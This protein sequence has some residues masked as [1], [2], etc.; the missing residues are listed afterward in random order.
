[1]ITM[2]IIMVSWYDYHDD[3]DDDCD[4][5]DNDDDDDFDSDDDG[6]VQAAPVFLQYSYCGLPHTAKIEHM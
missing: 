1:M 3:D 2:I 6:D 4:G 5:H